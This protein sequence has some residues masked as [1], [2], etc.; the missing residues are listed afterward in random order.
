M[1]TIN[2]VPPPPTAVAQWEFEHGEQLFTAAIDEFAT[3]GY[4]Q[5]SIN[6][7]LKNAGMSKGQFYYHFKSKEGLY[8]A[9]I[10][11]LITQK[12]AFMATV[13]QPKDFQQDIFT[14]LQ[15]LIKYGLAF[16]RTYPAINRF[17]ESFVR[18]QGQPI[19]EK[20]ITIHNFEGNAGLN[21]LIELAY[22]RGD[23]RE[24]VSLPFVKKLVGFLFTHV[25]ELT[26]LQDPAGIEQNLTDFI[27][28]LQHGLARPWADEDAPTEE[29]DGHHQRG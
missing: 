21:Q 19:Y 22:A 10:D 26:D 6:A 25:T 24:D 7:I 13:L 17:S 16:S 1:S 15:K 28:F 23:F 5:A 2:P 12:Q 4:E 3:A 20:A 9:L 14:I 27:H 11:V 8:L 18:E 29:S